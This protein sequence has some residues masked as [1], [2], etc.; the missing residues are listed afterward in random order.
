[1]L[2]VLCLPVPAGAQVLA[3]AWCGPRD[4]IAR[5]LTL[6]EGA[7][8]QGQGI[9]D[10][11]SLMELWARPDGGWTLVVAYANGTSCIVG[12]GEA[13]EVAAAPRS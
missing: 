5:A 10:P 12:Q 7:V 13:W 11:D 9:R 2:A 4:Q 6:R 1:M 3:D 8:R